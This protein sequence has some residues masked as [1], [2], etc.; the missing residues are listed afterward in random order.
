MQKAFSFFPSQATVSG[1]PPR[2]ARG[3]QS[4]F[5]G[6]AVVGRALAREV[7]GRKLV[8]PISI[9]VLAWI[10]IVDWITSYELDLSPFY[11]LVIVLVTWNCGWVW[12]LVF[13][14]LTFANQI[15]IGLVI[16]HPFS[17]RV[18]FLVDNFNKLFSYLLAIG[19][20]A[21]LKALYRRLDAHSAQL[22]VRVA[23]RTSQLE[24]AIEE[25]E[26]FT[27]AVAH[28]FRAPL[29]AI[30]GYTGLVA[31]ELGSTVSED[32]KSYLRRIAGNSHYLSRLIDDLLGLYRCTREPLRRES[33]DMREMAAFA[34]AEN[35]PEGSECQIRIWHLPECDGD[36]QMVRE[37]MSQLLSNAVKFSSRNAAPLVEIGYERDAYFVRDNGVGFDAQYAGSLFGIF[38]RLH[39]RDDFEG[40]GVG[41]ALAKRI[42]ERHGGRIWAEGKLGQG[43]VFHFTL[44]AP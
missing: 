11:L 33:L 19:L 35:L 7:I 3:S 22:E 17:E 6:S 9:L 36:R 20:V 29:R 44:D 4:S 34:I 5:L 39:L 16:G 12:G 2:A 18:Y 43:A 8:L 15:A 27:Y 25:L 37:L 31:A 23:D 24:T 21:W 1:R 42:V 14:L 30:S 10:V 26:G 32:G 41:L 28:D 38:N 13:A 40:T